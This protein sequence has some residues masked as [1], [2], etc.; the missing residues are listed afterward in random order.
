[1]DGEDFMS[2]TCAVDE[3]EAQWTY[4][5]GRSVV[6]GA[7]A[8]ELTVNICA[9][10]VKGGFDAATHCVATGCTYPATSQL[11]IKARG[12]IRPS[13]TLP[14]CGMHASAALRLDPGAS[15]DT[16]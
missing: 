10:H 5:V 9:A 15:V 16:P 1:M 11:K 6:N 13:G 7:Y 8:Y 14:L 3:R 2:A 4:Q 12:R